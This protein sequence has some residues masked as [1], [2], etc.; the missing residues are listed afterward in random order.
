VRRNS[1]LSLDGHTVNAKLPH[2]Q[3]QLSK[4]ESIG[5]DCEQD[6]IRY[7]QPPS[8]V[9]LLL[10]LVVSDPVGFDDMCSDDE[11]LQSSRNCEMSARRIIENCGKLSWQPK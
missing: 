4:I 3:T 7:A 2:P 5:Y 9:S 6:L 10:T 11:Y 8:L 1:D